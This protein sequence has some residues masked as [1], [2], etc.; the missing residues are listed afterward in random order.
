MARDPGRPKNLNLV[1]SRDRSVRRAYLGRGKGAIPLGVYGTADYHAALAEALSRAPPDGTVHSLIY[2][3]KQ[4]RAFRELRPRTKA[5]Y[6]RHLDHIQ[7]HF[8]GLSLRAMSA[9]RMAEH[10]ERWR[11]K[12]EISAR[13][14]DYR[15]TV[16]KLVLGWGVDKGRLSHNR[17]VKLDRITGVRFND[18]RGTF[19]TRRR[20]MGWT[21]EEMALCSGH[22]VAGERG[23]QRFYA[24]RATIAEA[25]ARRLYADW[26]GP[27]SERKLQTGVQT[28]QDAKGLRS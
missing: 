22:Q 25:N 5:D 15:A 21:S 20:A 9:P 2:D 18:L 17:A 23:A 27:N 1:W 7:E 11:D 19:V 24:G 6:L 13:Q 3:Y 10:I 26:Y 8:G 4:S 16:L 14:A 28:A 12:L